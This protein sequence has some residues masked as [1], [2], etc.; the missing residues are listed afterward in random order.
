MHLTGAFNADGKYEFDFFH[1]QRNSLNLQFNAMM[2]QQDPVSFQPA[3][4]MLFGMTKDP[5]SWQFSG[6]NTNPFR[7]SYKK[8]RKV[9]NK[10]QH[11]VKELV[12]T[13]FCHILELH[14]LHSSDDNFNHLTP[15]YT[16]VTLYLFVF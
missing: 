13:Q 3:T 2:R 16:F 15:Y 8:I 14:N 12:R 5:D 9:V 6:E 4:Y 1:A 11:K 10:W 7:T